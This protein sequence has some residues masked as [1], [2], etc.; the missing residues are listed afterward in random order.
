VTAVPIFPLGSVLLP[1]MP[2]ALSIFEDRYVVMMARV[3]QKR[4][5]FGIVLIERGSEVGGGDLRFRTGTMAQITKYTFEDGILHL[6]AVGSKRFEVDHWL[7]ED[8]HPQAR[9]R[10][11]PDL[12]WS[13]DLR[14]L[15]DE[16]EALVR[17]TLAAAT[18]YGA[19]HWPAD[20]ALSD[21]PTQAVWQLAGISPI[22]PLDQLRLLR[23]VSMEDL[24]R[25][26]IS[27]TAAAAEILPMG[28]PE[29]FGGFADG[30]QQPRG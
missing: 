8:P 16:A 17:Q 22:G 23:S 5:E 4:G 2:T 26:I 6:T 30:P 24:L 25:S 1:S 10:L 18:K 19:P 28:W 13:D 3:L 11:L 20:L 27:M 7:L 14:P 29:A 15:R 9:I 21:D 12:D